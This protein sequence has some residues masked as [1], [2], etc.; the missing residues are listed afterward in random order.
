[1]ADKLIETPPEGAKGWAEVWRQDLR[2]PTNSGKW[3][4]A[5]GRMFLWPFLAPIFG[6]LLDRQRD[7][8]VATLE[9]LE[10]LHGDIDAL[11]NDLARMHREIS[12]DTDRRVHVGLQRNDAL[13]G[14]IDQKVEAVAARVR[15]LST[16]FLNVP[17][18]GPAREDFV[19]RRL[20]DGLR[21]SEADVGRALA[22]YL[23]YAE[24]QNPVIDIGCGRGEFLILCNDLKIPARGFD[25]NER[26]IA[27]LLDRGFDVELDSAPR[28]LRKITS[29]SVGTIFASHVVEHVPA[30]ALISLFAESARILRSGGYLLIET[31]NAQSLA[32]SASDF[33]RDP[34]HLAPRHVAAL[35][36]IAREFGFEVAELKTID[37]FPEAN[38]L[39]SGS[40]Q[41]DDLNTIVDRL[42][43]ILFGNQNL[44]LVLRKMAATA[45]HP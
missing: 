1:M 45:E 42:N 15:D 39:P 19:Y 40:G 35:T 34:T 30:D 41:S 22:P 26:S 20:E 18:G 25:T 32:M 38:L 14:A 17:A 36:L 16:P 29:R 7:F 3:R 44:R 28:C 10:G 33:W 43:E 9:L 23:R 24:E 8:N 21:G 2:F 13:F 11:R 4:A 37:P 6:P 27:D 31:P 12:A 5:L